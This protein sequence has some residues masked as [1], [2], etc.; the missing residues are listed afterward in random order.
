MRILTDWYPPEIKPVRDGF[1][2]TRPM[3]MLWEEGEILYWRKGEW[4]WCD[5]ERFGGFQNRQWRGLAF[6]PGASVVVS[7]EAMRW[8]TT[9]TEIPR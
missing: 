5:G 8:A 6:D 9:P 2:L 1:Y 4:K 7:S 3:S